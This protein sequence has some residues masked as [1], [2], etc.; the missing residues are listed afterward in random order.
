MWGGKK[1]NNDGGR[2]RKILAQIN[3][4]F[5]LLLKFQDVTLDY[6]KDCRIIWQS[7]SLSK[8]T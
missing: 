8:N 1:A 5:I 6:L 2:L 3:I 7:N 4:F